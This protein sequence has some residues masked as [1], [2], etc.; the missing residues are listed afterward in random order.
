M[1]AKRVY[2]ASLKSGAGQSEV[3]EPMYIY[4]ANLQ[5]LIPCLAKNRT[6]TNT[7]AINT[8]SNCE[9]LTPEMT[10]PSNTDFE[11]P[12]N[13]TVSKKRRKDTLIDDD[14]LER[15]IV[16]MNKALQLK[17]TS[18]TQIDD[19]YDSFG[20]I[21]A[22]QLR[23]ICRVDERSGLNAQIEIMAA[24]RRNRY[25]LDSATYTTLQ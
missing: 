2:E 5:F 1:R 15:S 10:P 24:I 11:T 4:W 8:I 18:T 22:A 9:N 23:E 6:L 16:D 17:L 25:P 3:K 21:V 13:P 7:I 14:A 12:V 19:Q 20:K